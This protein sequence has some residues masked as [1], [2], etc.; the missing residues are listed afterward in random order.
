MAAN[1]I[2]WVAYTIQNGDQPVFRVNAIGCG[3]AAFYLGVFII[4]TKAEARKK[5]ATLL[6]GTSVVLGGLWAG[7]T[8]GVADK[9]ARITGLGVVA[10]AC[11]VAMYG[12][13]I[14]AIVSAARDL[15]PDLIPLLLTSVNTVLSACWM[16]YGLLV[17][18]GFLYGPN[19]AGTAL[20]VIQLAVAIY[21]NVRVMRDPELSEK[22]RRAKEGKKEKGGVSFA[23]EE[24]LL[25]GAD[26]DSDRAGLIVNAA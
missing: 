15:D 23:G 9:D 20:C 13:P 5:L 25:D 14:K 22:R 4:Y 16:V 21:V 19:M 1:F 8:Y 12:A 17:S 24:E 6:V 10:V 3:F 26:A 2:S 18:N 7:I 11:N